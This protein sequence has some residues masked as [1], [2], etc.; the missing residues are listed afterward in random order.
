MGDDGWEFR[1]APGTIPDTVNGARFLRDVYVKARADYTGRVTVPVLWDKKT[2]TIVCNESRAVLRMLDHEFQALATRDVDYCPPEL[3]VEVDREID[4]LYKPVNNGVYRAGFATKQAAYEQAVDELFAALDG[5]DERLAK[6]RYLLG[7]KLT[8]ADICLFTT[9]LR[10]DPVY[11]YHFKCNL[12]KIVSYPQLSNY[13]RELYQL[14]GVA[15]LCDLGHIKEHYYTSHPRINP[16]RIIPKG[17]P[18][19][20]AAPHDRAR[21]S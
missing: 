7:S 17:P 3:Q 20:L 2:S 5:Y 8:E 1:E 12:R 10:F 4:A 21:F 19:N 18:V 14:P 6:Q 16:S 13:L 11:H 9:L 15:E